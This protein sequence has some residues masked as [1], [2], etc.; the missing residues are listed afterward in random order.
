MYKGVI[1]N[2]YPGGHFTSG[3]GGLEVLKTAGLSHFG[4]IFERAFPS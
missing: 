1:Q 2:L 4:G 3:W